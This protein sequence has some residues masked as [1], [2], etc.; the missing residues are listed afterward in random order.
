MS[1]KLRQL[2]DHMSDLEAKRLV[3]LGT[4]KHLTPKRREIEVEIAYIQR[5][6][7][8]LRKAFIQ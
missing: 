8:Q 6:I 2:K 1:K 5:D 4:T 3:I 7:A